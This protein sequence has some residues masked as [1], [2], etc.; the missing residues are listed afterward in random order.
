MKWS[1]ITSRNLTVYDVLLLSSVNGLAVIC[2][3]TNYHFAPMQL[4]LKVMVN[5]DCKNTHSTTCKN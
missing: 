2:N 5:S 1:V 3:P 4:K